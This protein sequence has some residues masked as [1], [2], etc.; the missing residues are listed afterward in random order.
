MQPQA[1]ESPGQALD[2]FRKGAE[3]DLAL[4]DQHLP[5]IDGVTVAAE[6]QKQPAAAMLPV[7]LLTP[8]GKKSG[9]DDSRVVFSHTVNKPVKPAQLCAALE[10]ALLSPRTP[11]RVPEAPKT[12]SSL[13]A[14]LPLRLLLVDDNAIN[15]KVAVR[16]L[17]QLGYQPA[18]AGNG[19][20]TL[21]ALDREPY[22]FIFMDVMMPEMDGLEATRL[23]RKRQMTG[24]H[25]NYQ[26][27]I[28][29]V[30]MTAHAMQGDREKCIA[31]GMD[32]YLAKPVRPKDVRDMVE[33]WGGKV[34]PEAR[35]SAT[36][37]S[38]NPAAE[39]PVDMERMNDLTDGN[40]DSLRELVEMYLKQTHKQFDQMRAAI[41]NQDA[42]EIRRV[43]HSCA[44]ASATLG[45][46]RLV[47]RLRELEKLGAS[48]A[49]TGAGE[50]CEHAVREYGC[51]QEFLKTQP[52][53]AAVV[54]GFNPA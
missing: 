16:I 31:A 50:I 30:A 5:G 13:A 48:G 51:I 37:A 34:M 15:Q 27:R 52:D 9:G 19:R 2:L 47:P 20:E 12:A 1:V 39:P 24:D 17:Q 21:E 33:K 7:V 41:R 3:F 54:A 38:E 22:D 44:G 29:I 28:V 46:T 4:I 26:S 25:F 11:A 40:Q 32:D 43:A 23:I 35:M 49:L 10:R 36:A 53:L 8:L 42:A 45:M 6:L 18:V 14:R